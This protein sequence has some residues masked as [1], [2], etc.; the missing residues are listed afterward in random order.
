[1]ARS[2][3][4]GFEM[5]GIGEF[6]SVVGSPSIQTT[7]VRSGTYAMQV[8]N[9]GTATYA[10]FHSRPAGGV[11]AA[12]FRSVR[13]YLYIVSY[14]IATNASN[15]WSIG[16]SGGTQTIWLRLKEDGKLDLQD[17]SGATDNGNLI[18]SLNAWHSIKV[19][20]ST[21]PGSSKVYID[22]VSA[23]DA[24][25]G[26]S[27]AAQ[28]EMRLGQLINA[29]NSATANIFF[30]DVLVDD[31]SFS[32]SGLPGESK[33]ALLI[34]TAGNNAGG[35]TDGAGGTGDIHGS[36][37]NIPPT[38]V[39]ASTAAAKIKNATSTTTGDYVATM[40]SYSVGGVPAGSVVNAVV[41]VCNDGV[42]VTTGGGKPGAIWIASNPAQSAGTGTFDSG[43]NGVIEGTY[44]TGWATHEGVVGVAPSVTLGTAPTVTIRKNLASTR[45]VGCDFMGL[46]VDYTPP[47]I[48]KLNQSMQAVKRASFL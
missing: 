30:D 2:Y 43:D 36:V 15:I 38:G 19:D 27:S 20:V 34:P 37:D 46:Y 26:P 47:P 8:N 39:L 13:F 9:P 24:G 11:L 28:V 29:Q 18:I 32:V 3:I 4:C 5:G 35:W 33:L 44:P 22:G 48:G 31:N 12:I 14:P 23:L 7:T 6:N 16:A 17:S 10:V 21:T 40:Q 41:A 1:M 25:T 42:E 45:V